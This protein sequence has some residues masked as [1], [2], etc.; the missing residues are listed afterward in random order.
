MNYCDCFLKINFAF[1]RIAYRIRKYDVKMLISRKHFPAKRLLEASGN[2]E[3]LKVSKSN[4]NI[5]IRELIK[6]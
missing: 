4:D 1:N 2:Y 6:S 5:R 3:K